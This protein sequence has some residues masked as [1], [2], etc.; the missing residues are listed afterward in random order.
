MVCAAPVVAAPAGNGE[1]TST[2]IFDEKPSYAVRMIG[3]DGD[4]DRQLF[5][6]TDR[7]GTGATNAVWSKDGERVLFLRLRGGAGGGLAKARDLSIADA[8]GHHLRRMLA[9]VLVGRPRL[10]ALNAD[11]APEA[12]ACGLA[13]SSTVASV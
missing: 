2:A 8:G 1:I 13:R 9:T 7:F 3:G 5:G 12:V 4:D 10:T 11:F 6:P